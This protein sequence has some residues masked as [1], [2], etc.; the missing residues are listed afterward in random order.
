MKMNSKK[1]MQKPMQ[2]IQ[3]RAFPASEVKGKKSVKRTVKK[4]FYIVGMGGSAGALEAFEQF[5]NN[6]PPDNG[7][8]FVL[9]PHLDPTH[10][11]IMPELLQRTT[12]MKVFQASDEMKVQANSVYVIPPNKDMSIL[13]GTLQL[14]EPL[15]PRGMRMPIDYFFRHLAEDQKERSICIILSGMATDGTMGIKAVKEKLGIVMVQDPNTAK[16]NSMPLSAI[17]TGIVDYIAR[18]EDLPAKLLQY[19]KYSLKVPKIGIT[20]TGKAQSALQKICILIR[21][22]TGHDFSLYKKNTI[23]RRIERRMSLHQISNITQYIRYLQENNGEITLLFNELLIGVTN[24]FRDPKAFEILRDEVFPQMI[25]S[26]AKENSIRIWIPGC[27]SGEEAYSIAIVIMECINRLK[28]KAKFKVSIFATDIDKEAIDKARFGLYPANIT[29]DVSPDRL[30]QFFIKEDTNYRIKKDIRGMIVFAPQNIIMD[31][32]FTKL[33]MICCRNLLIYLNAEV[34]KKLL[35]LFHYALKPKGILFLGSS[36]TIGSFTELFSVVDNKWKIFRRKGLVTPEAGMVDLPSS[37]LPTAFKRIQDTGRGLHEIESTLSDVVQQMLIEDYAP[38]SLLINENGDILY[39]SGRTGKFLEP[40]SGK[41]AMNVYSMAREGLKY[42]V[43]TAIRRAVAQ[44]TAVT[45]SGL[46]VRTNGGFQPLNLT[47]KPVS[48]PEA[49]QSMF[50]I[51]FEDVKEATIEIKAVRVK[52]KTKIKRFQNYEKIENELNRAREQL[53]STTEEMETSQEELKSANEELQSTNEEVQSTNEEL[54]TSKEEL[55]SMNEELV[56]VNSEL[57]NKIDELSKS[58]NDM[59][60]LLNSTDIATI[61]VDNNVNIKRFTSPMTKV[62]NLIPT[63]IGRPIS[64]IVSNLQY[65]DMVKDIKE[66][67]QT[68]IFKELYVKTKDGK[69]YIMRIVPYRTI[70]NIIDGA[71]ITFVDITALKQLERSLRE[72]GKRYHDLY[73]SIKDGIAMCDMKGN[74][75]DCN[76]AYADMLGYTKEEIKKLT[77]YQ[78]TPKKWHEIENNIIKEQLIVKG[79]SGEYQKEYIKKDGTVF[80]IALRAWIIKDEN[81]ESTGIWGIVRDIAKN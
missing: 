11:G 3:E 66:V 23:Y 67:L 49:M 54:T 63:D 61:F 46:K 21:S 26:M 8:A 42:E 75:L 22:Q 1:V 18:A 9:V 37:L 70:D 34:Q 76:Q 41:A 56:T 55:Q 28:Q 73:E 5:F 39:V 6:M 13:H 74:F 36:E 69:H 16:Y 59:R 50:L 38:P 80:P 25:K 17:K 19:V 77:F 24:F 43:G 4:P 60:N 51:I 65:E 15:M 29:A 33:D 14:M 30:Q 52:G 10:K 81:G 2:K 12:K 72:S 78:I 57:N 31:P 62:I 45:M 58:N 7:M 27:S 40:S 48:R 44:K 79:Y 68:L 71:V 64:H 20:A 35:P 47:V 32:P 53:Q